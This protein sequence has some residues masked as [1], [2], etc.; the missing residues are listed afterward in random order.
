MDGKVLS[1]AAALHSGFQ[2]GR[3]SYQA[4][5]IPTG[6]YE[7]IL[8]AK[9]WAK[10]IMGINCYFTACQTG[11][12][13]QLTV[14]CQKET[15]LYRL[16]GGKLDFTVCPVGCRYVIQVATDVIQEKSRPSFIKA[17]LIK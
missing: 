13:F 7:V 10:K 2:P 14:Y 6:A 1:W 15:G 17:A 3:Y 4:A 8:D 11:T 12:K 5:A 9:I 16:R